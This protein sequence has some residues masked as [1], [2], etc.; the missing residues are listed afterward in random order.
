MCVVTIPVDM[1]RGTGRLWCRYSFRIHISSFFGNREIFESLLQSQICASEQ[2]KI[3]YSLFQGY[4]VTG[5][6]NTPYIAITLNFFKA[7]PK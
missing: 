6:T 4:E 3:F 2:G 5:I 1:G 7:S